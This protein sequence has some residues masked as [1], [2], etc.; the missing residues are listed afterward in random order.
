MFQNFVTDHIVTLQVPAGG[1]LSSLVAPHFGA[2]PVNE[3]SFYGAQTGGCCV[4]V[5]AD[6][7]TDTLFSYDIASVFRDDNTEKKDVYGA[8]YTFLTT[9]V[10]NGQTLTVASSS[11]STFIPIRTD[12]SMSGRFIVPK[13]VVPQGQKQF[14]AI[15]FFSKLGAE[16][17]GSNEIAGSIR[18]HTKEATVLQ[19]MK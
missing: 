2:A 14:V 4:A 19:P 6:I 3:R 16:I 7:S 18:L 1:I 15:G 11:V 17:T 5:V 9:E 10:T 12:G 8:A 13:M